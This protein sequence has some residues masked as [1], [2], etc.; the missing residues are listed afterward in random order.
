M[1]HAD[2]PALPAGDRNALD[3]SSAVMGESL[4][5]RDYLGIIYQHRWLIAALLLLGTAAAA[6]YN[7]WSPK[8][9]E[10]SATLQLQADPN[11][12]GLDRPVQVERDR[13]S[14]FVP[15]E[16]G[17][18]ESR[19]FARLTRRALELA[20]NGDKSDAAVVPHTD[21]RPEAAL[22]TPLP[23]VEEIIEGRQ[24]SSVQDTRL[25][26][27]GFRSTDPLRAAQI[28]NA[29]A[30]A[31]VARSLELTSSTAGE[32]SAW[33]QKQVEEQR[34][35]VEES[36]TALQQYRML[37][38][39]E[40]LGER[41]N[42]H[43]DIVAQKLADLQV[44]LTK[45]RT[46]TIEKEA[47][48]QQLL[49]L[50]SNPNALDTLPAIA[51]SAFIQQL[52]QELADRQQQLA[53]A[54]EELGERHPDRVKLQTEV[55]T[56]ER[57]LRSEISTLAAS[58][59]NDY[60][61]ARARETALSATF[62]R[63][64]LEVRALDAKAVEYTTLDRSANANRALLDDLLQRASQVTLSRD[65][66]TG[67]VRVVDAA[68][69]PLEPVL[70]RKLRNILLALFGSGALSLA[71]VFLLEA[72]DTRVRT[73]D[74]VMR[75]LKIPVLGIAPRVKK[76]KG[77]ASTL[78]SDEAP[79]QFAELL[80]SVRTQILAARKPTYGRTLVV[81]SSEPAAG[82]T[83]TAANIALSLARIKQRVLLIDADLR[84][85]QL[86]EMFD[87]ERKPGLS[88][89][90]GQVSS[91]SEAVRSTN[92]PLLWL[93]PAGS[94]SGQPSDLLS[95]DQFAK[96]IEEVREQFDWV[97]LDSP[98]VL[99][100]TDACLMAREV[101]GV[102]F[103]IRAGR[104]SRDVAAAAIERLHAVGGH[105]VGAILNGVVL[106]RRDRSYLPY[107]HRDY[108]AYYQPSVGDQLFVA[109]RGPRL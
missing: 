50:T 54:S 49:R 58:I 22:P 45:A 18:L 51:S 14:E 77:K 11:V 40:A 12:L 38:Q 5:I 42:D 37:H 9:F 84:R 91:S 88:D 71:L 25:I 47:Q 108:H 75:H 87:V 86:H 99:A 107:Y 76:L 90:L 53:Q 106:K 94:L 98:P 57:K 26:T 101:G 97:I 69:V 72:L 55:D 2:E 74:D 48:Y 23:T 27:V 67:N 15:T 32:G 64:K 21:S 80:R 13:M 96:V 41:G 93:L 92:I 3:N 24:I 46:E 68:D 104:T 100:V 63:Q 102:L 78:L 1:L 4:Q 29:M 6:V 66:P 19:D 39:A 73:P 20:A 105:V 33:L 56:A 61:S 35:R 109:G 62:E 65:L 103:V 52:K 10:A 36:E 59:R 95:G 8:V 83:M 79:P 34:K 60:E 43:Q 31:Y 70:P 85:P 30:G 28:A 82:K 44:A 81:T 16:V 17:V 89:I 7:S